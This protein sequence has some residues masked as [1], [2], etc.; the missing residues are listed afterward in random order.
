MSPRTASVNIRAI[1]QSP[2]PPDPDE[3]VILSIPYPIAAQD[4]I[5]VDRLVRELGFS[6][7][8]GLQVVGLT[9][10][11]KRWTLDVVHSSAHAS[12]V[13]AASPADIY[14]TV[15][16]ALRA[17]V[18]PE[19]RKAFWSARLL[20]GYDAGGAYLL[21]N[22]PKRRVN[23]TAKDVLDALDVAW[24]LHDPE[25]LQPIADALNAITPGGSA[26]INGY[27]VRRGKV[28]TGAWW[29]S[30]P[31]LGREFGMPGHRQ[32]LL[33]PLWEAAL[34]ATMGAER[35]RSKRRR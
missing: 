16:R 34:L 21:A 12:S 20:G 18:D 33:R 24:R 28:V 29:I 13:Q 19:F 7:K 31:Y 9:T 11:V 32:R 30:H 15:R 17:C 8:G 26:K 6:V 10:Q 3:V 22:A 4:V 35:P 25:A 23:R 2:T 5:R 14:A 1:D 27:V